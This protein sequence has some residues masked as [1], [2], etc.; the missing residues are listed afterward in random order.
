[1]FSLSDPPAQVYGIN[2]QCKLFFAAFVLC[3]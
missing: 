3:S 1:L 2:Q